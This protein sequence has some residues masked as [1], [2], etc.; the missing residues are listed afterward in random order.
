MEFLLFW[1]SRLHGNILG[2]FGP[3]LRGQF[4]ILW[5]LDDLLHVS[6]S[7]TSGDNIDDVLVSWHVRD[8]SERIKVD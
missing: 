5:A 8:I 6:S 3:A 1:V 4:Q 7:A 2:G